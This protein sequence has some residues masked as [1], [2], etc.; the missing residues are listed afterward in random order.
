[1]GEQE[2]YHHQM[3]TMSNDLTFKQSCVQLGRVALDV[4]GIIALV[5]M[6]EKWVEK[7]KGHE[8]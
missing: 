3:E 2:T 8:R 5:S 7:R 4:T 1:M 6:L